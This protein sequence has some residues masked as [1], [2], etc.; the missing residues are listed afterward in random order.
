[1]LTKN[2]EI[3]KKLI[4]TF[5]LL[6]TVNMFFAQNENKVK[7]IAE[8]T[9]QTDA[10][11]LAQGINQ[12]LSDDSYQRWV[13]SAEVKVE[14]RKTTTA[15]AVNNKIEETIELYPNPVNKGTLNIKFKFENFGSI[16]LYD[17]TGKLVKQINVNQFETHHT[18]DVA[19]LTAGAYICLI[20]EANSVH[21][22]KVIVQ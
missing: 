19:E 17:I 8:E 6:T 15:Q 13:V 11:L 1:M 14:K 12:T 18:I 3:M 16:A 20:Q 7:T 10:T 4:V 2:L 22:Q 9:T 21:S 5:S